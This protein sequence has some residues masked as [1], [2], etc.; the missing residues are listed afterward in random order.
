G[1][2]S[3]PTAWKVLTAGTLY[4]LAS[5]S[6]IDIQPWCCRSKF[7]TS[8][9]P[10]GLNVV[11]LICSYLDHFSYSIAGAYDNSG[12]IVEPPCLCKSLASLYMS[13]SLLCRFTPIALTAS[14]SLSTTDRH[15]SISSSGKLIRFCESSVRRVSTCS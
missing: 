11:S 10:S 1:P 14:V 3:Y 5:A 13:I 6:R 12:F 4:D 9:R 2:H 8:F 7:L 15:A